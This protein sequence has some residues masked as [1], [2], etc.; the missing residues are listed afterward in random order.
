MIL[1]RVLDAEISHWE[2]RF[3]CLCFLK[4]LLPRPLL[5]QSD[6]KY[7]IEQAWNKLQTLPPIIAKEIA[8]EEL[9]QC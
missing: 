8:W 5:L 7:R 9:T 1:E 2:C 3:V 4:N 6:S